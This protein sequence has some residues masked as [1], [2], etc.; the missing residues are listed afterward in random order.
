[1]QKWVHEEARAAEVYRK[2]KVA[3]LGYEQS[4]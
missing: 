3:A 1:L 4:P 2:L